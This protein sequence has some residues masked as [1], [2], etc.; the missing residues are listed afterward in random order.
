MFFSSIIAKTIAVL[1][2]RKKV[3]RFDE[4][5]KHIYVRD[6]FIISKHLQGI[7]KDTRQRN[8]HICYDV[9]IPVM[10]YSLPDVWFLKIGFLHPGIYYDKEKAIVKRINL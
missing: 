6:P 4:Y 2:K 1:G 8:Q 3:F 7:Y 9:E 5:I 10:Y